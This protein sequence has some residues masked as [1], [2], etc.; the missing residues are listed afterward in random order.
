MESVL[1]AGDALLDAPVAGQDDSLRQEG[2]A[3]GVELGQRLQA[4]QLVLNALNAVFEDIQKTVELQLGVDVDAGRDAEVLLDDT[5]TTAKLDLGVARRTSE[6]CDLIEG[7]GLID[8][9]G[10]IGTDTSIAV[11]RERGDRLSSLFTIFIA[12]RYALP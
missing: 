6:I 12:T 5:C 1:Q 9:K 8:A 7:I 11:Q 3:Q 10:I 2:L 4:V